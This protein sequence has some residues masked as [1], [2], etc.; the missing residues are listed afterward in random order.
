VTVPPPP[1]DRGRVLVL[2]HHPDEGP[3]ALGPLLVD[4][5]LTLDIVELDQG[6]PVPPLEP[7]DVMLAMGGPMDVWQE[8]VHSWL[9]DEKAAIRH[10]V[11]VLGRPFLGV[12]LGHQ[13]LAT[14]L[15]GE[16]APM[17]VPEI[18]VTDMMLSATGRDDPIFGALPSVVPGLQWHGAEIA[19]PPADAVVLAGNECCGVQALRVDKC[20]WGVQFHVEAGP[21]TVQT[22]AVVPEYAATLAHSCGSAASLQRDVSLHLDAMAR[23][24]RALVGGLVDAAV[25]TALR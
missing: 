9:L 20:A 5:G 25:V 11:E 21:A 24:A 15:G 17:P 23:I 1:S 19:L 16:V 13:L 12:C 14:A 6:Q 22:W 3:G 2:Q 4:A 18:G 8:D 10:W 7:F